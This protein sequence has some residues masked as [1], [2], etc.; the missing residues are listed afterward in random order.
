MRNPGLVLMGV[1]AWLPGW[2]V[3]VAEASRRQIQLS[4]QKLAIS[5]FPRRMF[6][7]MSL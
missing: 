4:A 7:Y 3:L 5:S 6:C 1:L 2:Q